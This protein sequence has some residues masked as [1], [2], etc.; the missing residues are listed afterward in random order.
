VDDFE[1]RKKELITPLLIEAGAALCDCQQFEFGI[2]LLLF[3]F[4][5]LGSDGLD[6]ANILLILDNKAKKTAGQLIVM[7]KKHLKLSPGIEEALEAALSARNFLIHRSLID[8]A[9]QFAKA[10]TRMALIKE[11]RRSRAKV[12]KADKMLQPFI[13]G[14]SAALDGV[15]HAKIE[16]E[17]RDLLS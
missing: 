5:R 14:L 7:F 1:A 12:Q 17:V 9:E 13:L 6:T 10:D 11:I 8:N 4:S 3:H 2:A 15:E 16:M